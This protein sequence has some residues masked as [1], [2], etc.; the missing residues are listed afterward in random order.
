[1]NR[2]ERVDRLFRKGMEHKIIKTKL[3]TNGYP[4]ICVTCNRQFGDGD[5]RHEWRMNLTS[6]NE[7]HAGGFWNTHCESCFVSE[8]RVWKN[9][10]ERKLEEANHG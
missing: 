10:L 4:K 7:Y 1:M 9:T 3:L 5:I 2:E 6:Q 8:L